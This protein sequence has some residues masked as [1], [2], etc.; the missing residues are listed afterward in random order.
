MFSSLF[1]PS[2]AGANCGITLFKKSDLDGLCPGMDQD[3]DDK[4][5]DL[6]PGLS[7]SLKLL[8]TPNV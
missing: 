6:H 7:G 2:P 1:I 8:K 4:L 5:T 3:I